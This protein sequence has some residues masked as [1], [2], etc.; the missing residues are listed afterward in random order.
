[1]VVRSPDVI[2]KVKFMHVMFTLRMRAR[3]C[4]FGHVWDSYIDAPLERMATKRRVWRTAFVGYYAASGDFLSTFRGN[5]AA[6]SSR[7]K[8]PNEGLLV[9][10]RTLCREECSRWGHPNPSYPT[11]WSYLP[12]RRLS[13]TSTLLWT[14]RMAWLGAGHANL[15]FTS[16]ERVDGPYRSVD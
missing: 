16:L 4:S 5:L 11:M 1:M 15:S 7:D 13:W 14:G 2:R 6:L 12:G 3:R 9:P 10:I 8:K